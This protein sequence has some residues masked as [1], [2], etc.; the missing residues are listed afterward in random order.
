MILP[1]TSKGE[2][3][4]FE[5]LLQ[6]N[7][8]TRNLSIETFNY[9][10][11]IDYAKKGLSVALIPQRLAKDIALKQFNIDLSEQIAVSYVEKNYPLHQKRFKRV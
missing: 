1:I 10:A 11:S 7:G 3:K 9:I 6:Q 5:N 2:Q 4:L 8:I